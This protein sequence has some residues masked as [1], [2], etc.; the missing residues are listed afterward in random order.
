VAA[1]TPINNISEMCSMGTLLAFAMVC[2]AVLI[3]R[4]KEPGLDRPYKTPLVYFVAPMGVLFNIFLMTQVRIH[5]WYAFMIW[6]G[7]G[8]LVYFLYSRKNSNLNKL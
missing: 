7:L 2:L 4:K 3:L 1:V 5:T 6:G 8:V